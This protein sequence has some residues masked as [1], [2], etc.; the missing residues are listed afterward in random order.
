MKANT[1]NRAIM[2]FEFLYKG[3]HSVVPELY[4][5]IVKTGQYPRPIWVERESLDSARLGFQLR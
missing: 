2:F 3:A 1:A 4:R 5:P